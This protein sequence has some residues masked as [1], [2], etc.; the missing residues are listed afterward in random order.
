MSGAGNR[1]TDTPSGNWRSWFPRAGF[2]IELVSKSLLE[3]QRQFQHSFSIRGVH[4]FLALRGLIDRHLIF[5]RSDQ[6]ISEYLDGAVCK[7]KRLLDH[8]V[9]G[10]DKH[11]VHV[12]SSVAT[13]RDVRN[14][15]LVPRVFVNKGEVPGNQLAS[16]DF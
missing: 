9:R 10:S 7:E 11:L 15:V 12:S 14:S 13:K 16:I 5:K 3:L 1:I 2:G 4:K 8:G 6:K